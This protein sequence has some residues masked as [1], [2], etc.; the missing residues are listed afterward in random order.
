MI[1]RKIVNVI[2]GL[3]RQVLRK[4]RSVENYRNVIEM[5]N[6]IIAMKTE[7]NISDNYRATVIKTLCLLSAYRNHVDFRQ[8][9][10]DDLL[11]YLDSRRKSESEE[12]CANLH[13]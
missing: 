5:T 13:R 1:E 7:V 11:A 10:R 2:E 4:R 3:P 9:T 12:P 8:L 6:Y